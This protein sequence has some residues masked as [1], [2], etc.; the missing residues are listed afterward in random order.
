MA[1]LLQLKDAQ[2]DRC[3]FRATTTVWTNDGKVYGHYCRRHGT[4]VLQ[5]LDV[6]ERFVARLVREHRR[7]RSQP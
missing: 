1:S 5:E 3:T 4:I 2:C 7:K 6:L